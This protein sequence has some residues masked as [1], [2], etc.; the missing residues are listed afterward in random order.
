MVC[1]RCGHELTSNVCSYCG[2]DIQANNNALQTT[3]APQQQYVNQNNGYM[4]PTNTGAYY[5][6]PNTNV[7]PIKKHKTIAIVAFVLSFLGPLAL[8]GIILAIVDINKDKQK[9]YKHA[10]SIAAIVIGILALAGT[11]RLKDNFNNDDDNDVRK[12]VSTSGSTSES[13]KGTKSQTTTTP[14]ATPTPKPENIKVG[15]GEEF[16]NDTIKGAVVYADLDYKGYND[17]LTTVEKGYKAIYVKI[18][19]TNISKESN[20]VSVGDYKCY[21]DNI[22]T[23]A[24]ILS[25]GDESYNENISPGRSAILG[26]MYKVPENTKSIELEY[27]PIG[28]SSNRQIIVI[29]DES[30]T[31]TKISIMDPVEKVKN[32]SF[33]TKENIINKGEEFGNKTIT[34]VV[35]SINLD[36]TDYNKYW[37]TIPEGYK[38]IYITIKVTNISNKTNYVSVG[39]YT[40]YVDNIA[41][42]AE[43]ISG[44]NEDYNENID[45]GRSAILGAMY[46]IPADSKSIELEYTPL[47]ESADSPIIK[48]Q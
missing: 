31:E 25:G 13:S 42:N 8:I 4:N 30:T 19:V 43:V 36:Y 1:P 37:T 20:Y 14:Q 6:N 18:L 32:S 9:Y 48:I 45:P 5:Y 41:V 12:T 7:N 16:G 47:G 38:A 15:M 17:I 3:G 22:A 44:G 46:I 33:V 39:D 29:Q 23:N 26:A 27:K 21:A 24:E 34:G 40:C 35:E 11:Y 10:F 28:E 2:L